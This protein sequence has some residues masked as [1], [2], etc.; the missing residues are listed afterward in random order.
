MSNESSNNNP[1][2]IPSLSITLRDLIIELE[3]I[4]P[5]NVDHPS[6]VDEVL[7]ELDASILLRNDNKNGNKLE[8]ITAWN[9]PP[10][11]A[12]PPLLR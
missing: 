11:V 3:G 6:R 2:C 8:D 9:Q 4:M 5:D 1:E 10:V 7:S 12:S